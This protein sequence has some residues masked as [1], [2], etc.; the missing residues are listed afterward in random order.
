MR[1]TA[2]AYTA[3]QC[4]VELDKGP[5]STAA[6]KTALLDIVVVGTVVLEIV[7]MGIAGPVDSRRSHSFGAAG[8]VVEAVGTVVLAGTA[9][10][11]MVQPSWI[12]ADDVLPLHKQAMRG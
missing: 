10:T 2:E 12:N 6:G 3:G 4:I 1:Y 5:V 9:D 11:G 8:T 7:G